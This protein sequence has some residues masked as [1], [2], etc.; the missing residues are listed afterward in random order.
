VPEP[1]REKIIVGRV[2]TAIHEDLAVSSGIAGL[3]EYEDVRQALGCVGFHDPS[4][5]R[6]DSRHTLWQAANIGFV[7]FFALGP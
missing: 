4:R 2:L 7:F 3:V 5:I 1:S 6:V